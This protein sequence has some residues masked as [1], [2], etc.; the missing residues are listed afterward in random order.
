MDKNV[1]NKYIKIADLAKDTISKDCPCS[2]RAAQ[3]RNT[4]W[5]STDKQ[6]LYTLQS[7]GCSR[8]PVFVQS[9]SVRV[10]VVIAL[11]VKQ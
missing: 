7:A 4:C 11:C 6:R 1:F 10:C 9:L 2:G 3:L 8:V 5:S